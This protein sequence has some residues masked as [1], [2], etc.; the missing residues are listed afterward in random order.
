[1]FQYDTHCQSDLINGCFEPWGKDNDQ[2]WAEF[3]NSEKLKSYTMSYP[4]SFLQSYLVTK[5]DLFTLIQLLI[6]TEYIK[7]RLKTKTHDN[8][9][10][11]VSHSFLTIVQLKLN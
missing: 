6:Q 4:I 7:L 9:I 8:S 5:P 1:M 2:H 10:M 3:L 11:I